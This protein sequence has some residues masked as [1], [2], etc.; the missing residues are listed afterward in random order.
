METERMMLDPF[1]LGGILVGVLLLDVMVA[2][3]RAVLGRFSLRELLTLHKEY[4]D[5]SERLIDFWRQRGVLIWWTQ[6]GALLA[7]F[8]L[9]TLLGLLLWVSEVQWQWWPW[10]LA[11]GALAVMLLEGLV[12]V[13]AE[14]RRGAW[15][16][17]VVRWAERGS[18]WLRPFSALAVRLF[19]LPPREG[20]TEEMLDAMAQVTGTGDVAQAEEERHMITSVVRFETLLVR[21]I[22]VPRIDMV[23]L[24]VT[25]TVQ[26]ALE[27]FLR[28]GFSRIPVYRETVDDIVGLLYAKDLLRVWHEGREVSTLEPLLRPA[29]FVPEA[30]RVGEL[31]TEMQARRIHMVIVVDEYGG[32]AGLVTL[33]DIVEE[34]VGEIQDEYDQAEVQL[35][36]QVGEGEYL[37]QARLDLDE[38]EDLLDVSLDGVEAAE[39]ADTVGGLIY[40]LIGKVPEGGETVRLEG[41]ELTVEQVEGRRIVSVRARRLPSPAQ[42]ESHAPS[43]RASTSH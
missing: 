16:L 32:V 4:P 6:A 10:V 20:F 12:A 28:T 29:Y 19:P 33:E 18:R 9:A 14:R 27:T 31:L 25:A 8:A 13:W 1:M 39:E 40:A 5:Q 7:H 21:E 11:L 3:W 36:R 30:K 35:W 41:V 22:M 38:F 17:R 43:R 37:I 23:T 42:E 24:A 26:E 2:F 34:I 15:G